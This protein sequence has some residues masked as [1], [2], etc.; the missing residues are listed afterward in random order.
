MIIPNRNFTFP[1]TIKFGSERIKELAEQCKAV[2]IS[3]PLFVTDPGLAKMVMVTAILDDLRVAGLGAELFSEVRPNPVEGNIAAG[4]K[5]Y[6]AGRHDG[7]I[8]FGGGSGLDVGKLIALMHGQ[9]ISVFDLEDVGDWWTRADANA[10]API[11]AVPT[12]AGTGSE[13]GR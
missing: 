1:T 2:G 12:T 6:R 9:K 13:V 7:V 8:A 3:R 5:A 10:I 11:I 4:I